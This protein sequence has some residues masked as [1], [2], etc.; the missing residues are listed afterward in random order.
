MPGRTKLTTP[1]G[2]QPSGP[3]DGDPEVEVYSPTFG[4]PEEP[5]FPS[6]W[7]RPIVVLVLVAVLAGAGYWLYLGMTARQTQ[8]PSLP[9]EPQS[10]R[11]VRS[12][13]TRA[14]TSLVAATRP[15]PWS[16]GRRGTR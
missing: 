7:R 8:D 15:R 6:R 11:G 10:E 13:D 9:T 14:A 3:G 4:L 5:D 16:P 2:E 12:G 1:P